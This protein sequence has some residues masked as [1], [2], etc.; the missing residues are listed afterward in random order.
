MRA[1]TKLEIG[2]WKIETGNWKI[3]TGDSTPKSPLNSPADFLQF[4]FSS[5]QFPCFHEYSR[6]HHGLVR[7]CRQARRFLEEHKLAFE[8]IDIE[9]DLRA[10]KFVKIANKANGKFLPSTWTAASSP[11]RPSTPKISSSNWDCRT[12]EP[13]APA[14]HRGE[15]P[16]QLGDRPARVEVLD[17]APNAPEAGDEGGKRNRRPSAD[18]L[19]LRT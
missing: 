6:L 16:P 10:A 5:F 4:P 19:P 15:V 8:E 3:K 11:V 12:R 18:P 9:E 7:D 17:S 1:E 13:H 2:N 14:P